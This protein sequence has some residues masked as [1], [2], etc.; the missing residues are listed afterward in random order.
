MKPVPTSYSESY[1]R[2]GHRRIIDGDH[3][4]VGNKRRKVC[5][6]LC[7]HS[8]IFFGHNLFSSFFFQAFSST[9]LFANSQWILAARDRHPFLSVV[10]RE[11]FRGRIRENGRR[12]RL[13]FDVPTNRAM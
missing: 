3:G 8:S 5:P 9:L 13:E 10:L 1:C 11:E 4:I 6:V 7:P 2:F 12:R